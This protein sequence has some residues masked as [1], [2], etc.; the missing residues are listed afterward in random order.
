[1][2]K[3]IIFRGKA[4][5]GKTLLTNL[6]SKELNIPVIRKDDV[7]DPLAQYDLPPKVINPVAYDILA[8]LIQTNLDNHCDLILDIA[9]AHTPY[10]KTFLSKLKVDGHQL[11][12]FLC[13][14]SDSEQWKKRIAERILHPTPNQLFT[15][16]EE[17]EQYYQ[18]YQIEQMEHEVILDSASVVSSLKQQVFTLLSS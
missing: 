7:Y 15:S 18:N 6:L 11:F 12:S 16:T 17:A 13:I 3:L 4:A 14:C 10:M 8:Q 9:L 2:S 5:T 1:M